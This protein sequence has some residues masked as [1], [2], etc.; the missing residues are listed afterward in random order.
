MCVNVVV[1]I[2]FNHPKDVGL[3]YF[4]HLKFAWA[5]MVRLGCMEFVMF[6]HGLFPF[7]WDHKFSNY[8]KN[9]QKRIDEAAI[10][11]PKAWGDSSTTINME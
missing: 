11:T 10:T 9:A 8:I 5:E 1:E 3:N 6:I 2:N 4:S 7:I